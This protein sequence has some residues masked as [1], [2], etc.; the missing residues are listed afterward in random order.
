MLLSIIYTIYFRKLFRVLYI[1]NYKFTYFYIDLIGCSYIVAISS[2]NGVTPIILELASEIASPISEGKLF[3]K[4]PLF[5]DFFEKV[6]FIS[7]SKE[8][9]ISNFYMHAY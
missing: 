4:N 5:Y 1:N 3:K 9:N 8:E 6:G 7:L 2:L